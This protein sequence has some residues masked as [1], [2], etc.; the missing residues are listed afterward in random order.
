MPIATTATKELLIRFFKTFSLLPS[1][2]INF[3]DSSKKAYRIQSKARHGEG[4]R[5]KDETVISFKSVPSEL[6]MQTPLTPSRLASPLKAIFFPSGDHNKGY[7]TLTLT[8][9]LSSV[10]SGLMVLIP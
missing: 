1:V 9:C 4:S 3:S 8:K 2:H 10:P 7:P 5:L 6:I